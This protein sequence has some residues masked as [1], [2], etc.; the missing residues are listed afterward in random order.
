MT[1]NS[2]AMFQPLT[3]IHEPS[4]IQ[5]LADGRFLVVED[6]EQHPF[7]VVT[8]DRDG[9]VITTALKPGFFKAFDNFWKLADLEGVTIDQT[10]N[11]YAITSHSRDEDGDEKKSR[12]KLV[13]FSIEG[14]RVVKPKVVKDLKPALLAAHPVLARAAADLDVKAGAGFNIEAL[15]MSTDQQRLLIG[16]RSPLLGHRAL[17]ASVENPAEMFDADAPPRI[18][19]A[20]I[21]LDL[22]GNGI[23]AM[24]H[25]PALNGYLISSGPATRAQVQFQVWFWSGVADEPARRVSV[26]GLPGFEHTEGISPAI[27]DGRQKIIFVSDD[28]S[29][30]EGRPA[31]FLLL[32]P[33]QL[34]IEP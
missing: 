20:L 29:R 28:G 13:R 3:G 5:Q 30:A 31:R 33:G 27:I 10:G 1:L 16:F 6:E 12:H 9:A 11:I 2:I 7:S 25:I 32:D 4:G 18:C 24:S 17:I 22:G 8:I 19:A 26:A 23:R 14:D 34:Q 15:E 21:T